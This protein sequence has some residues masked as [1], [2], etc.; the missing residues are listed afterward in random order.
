VAEHPDSTTPGPDP[1]DDA[2]RADLA[3]LSDLMAAGVEVDGEVQVTESTW[4]IY[5]HMTY[6]GEIVVGEYHDAAEA[7]AVFRAV[8]RPD[9]DPDPDADR[10]GPAG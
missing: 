10:T 4:V 2:V 8:S 3:A 5:G 1:G 7:T 6:D 9:P